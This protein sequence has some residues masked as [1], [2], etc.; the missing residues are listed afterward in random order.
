VS[1]F[2]LEGCIPGSPQ[3]IDTGETALCKLLVARW[4]TDLKPGEDSIPDV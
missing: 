3:G 4:L 1:Y 2:S